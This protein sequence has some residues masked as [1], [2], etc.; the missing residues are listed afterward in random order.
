MNHDSSRDIVR[1]FHVKCLSQY[2]VNVLLF[3]F[4]SLDV[5]MYSELKSEKPTNRAFRFQS[6]EINFDRLHILISSFTVGMNPSKSVKVQFKV[7][8]TLLTYIELNSTLL[9][10]LHT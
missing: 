2:D 8:M 5:C 6:S 10:L 3:Y 1:G 7:G 9:Q 4:I